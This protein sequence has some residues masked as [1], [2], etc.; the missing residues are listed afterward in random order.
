M[1]RTVAASWALTAIVGST[2]VLQ[3]ALGNPWLIAWS[4][5]CFLASLMFSIRTTKTA[6]IIRKLD[7]QTAEYEQRLRH[8][9]ESRKNRRNN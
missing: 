2:I 8:F 6:R 7:A 3:V 1:R 5:I 4:V 9:S